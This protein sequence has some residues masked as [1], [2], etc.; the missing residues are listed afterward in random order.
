[1]VLAETQVK[2]AMPTKTRCFGKKDKGMS[3]F[4][5]RSKTATPFY[6]LLADSHGYIF[7]ITNNAEQIRIT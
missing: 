1:M 6:S 5:M 2:V 4:G 7:T 3:V